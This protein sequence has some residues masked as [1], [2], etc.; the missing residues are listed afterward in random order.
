[1]VVMVAE[2]PKRSPFLTLAYATVAL[3]V[4][5]LPYFLYQANAEPDVNNPFAGFDE[6]IITLIC[7]APLMIVSVVIWWSAVLHIIIQLV[8]RARR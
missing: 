3:I 7:F 5:N 2:K 8:S 6:A 1:M 4:F